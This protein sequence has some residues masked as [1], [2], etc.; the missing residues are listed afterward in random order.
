VP[1]ADLVERYAELDIKQTIFLYD[2]D[3]E[4]ALA[5]ISFLKRRGIH[6]FYHLKGGFQA[7]KAIELPMEHEP[8]KTKE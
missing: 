2:E 6:N 7:A 4:G 1:A 8:V 5:I 3:G